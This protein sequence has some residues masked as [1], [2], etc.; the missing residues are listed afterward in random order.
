MVIYLGA[1]HRGFELKETIKQFLKDEGY[2][3]ADM[4]STEK[5]EG[6]DYV[7]FA[8]AVAEKVSSD[9]VQARGVLLCGSGMGMDVTANKFRHVRSVLGF[10]TD[11]VFDARHDDDA[12]VLSLASDFLTENDAKEIVKIFIKTPFGN[13]ERYRRR[14][15]KIADIENA[16]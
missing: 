14:L 7:D 13:E 2:E 3:V 11:Q 10:S 5:V 1:D 4:G 6:D 9:P 12:N 8:K 16:N 15:E